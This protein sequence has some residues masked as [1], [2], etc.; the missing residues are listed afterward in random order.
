MSWVWTGGEHVFNVN[1]LNIND[2]KDVMT[3]AFIT[4]LVCIILTIISTG[5]VCITHWQPICCRR[6]NSISPE[7]FAEAYSE[8]IQ[9]Y[10]TNIINQTV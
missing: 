7:D 5:L 2:L 8:F 4:Q 6:K 3:T 1:C 9:I 10:R